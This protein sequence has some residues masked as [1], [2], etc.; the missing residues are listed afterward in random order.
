MTLPTAG[1]VRADG[2]AV[3]V[4]NFGGGEI[5]V[6]NATVRLTATRL[7]CTRV[8]IGAPTTNH[9]VGEANTGNI[10]VGDNAN[11]NVEGGMTLTNANVA[12]FYL[13]IDDASKVYF[14]GFNAGDVVEVRV[15][16]AADSAVIAELL[17]SSS[18]SSEGVS[19]SSSSSSES[20]ESSASSASSSSSSGE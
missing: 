12:G 18:S 19:L 5:V 15:F 7:P 16:G 9:A 8:W 14:T 4:R 11:G 3:S 17:S 6:G 13:D 1:P 2:S 20:S 10:L